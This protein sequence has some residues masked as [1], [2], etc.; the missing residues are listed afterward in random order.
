[1]V[2]GVFSDFAAARGWGVEYFQIFWLGFAARGRGVVDAVFS[3]FVAAR[4]RGV[5]GGLFSDF[6]AA[7]GWGVLG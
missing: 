1:M 6:V 4:G 2:G 5:V 3:D 7:R